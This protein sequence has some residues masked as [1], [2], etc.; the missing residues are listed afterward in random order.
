MNALIVYAHEEP[1]SFNGALKDTAVP[2]LRDAGHTVE[3]SDLVATNFNPVGGSHDFTK[4]SDPSF[5]KYGVE[6][7]KATEARTFAAD[8]AAEQETTIQWIP[9]E[10]VSDVGA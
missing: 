6:Q 9:K 8:V 7:G 10:Y 5:F 1:K 3:V 2:V 4:L